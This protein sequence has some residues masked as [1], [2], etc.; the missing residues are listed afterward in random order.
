VRRDRIQILGLRRGPVTSRELRHALVP[1]LF[2]LYSSTD[3]AKAIR[4]LVASNI[5][6]R[7]NGVGIKDDEPLRFIE[8]A[9]GSLLN[10]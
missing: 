7:D 2:G 4:E 6:E 5:I 8:P 9:Q 3:Y 1:E 10:G